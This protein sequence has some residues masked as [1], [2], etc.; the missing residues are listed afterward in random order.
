[1]SPVKPQRRN[2]LAGAVGNAIEFYD[3]IIY[4]YLAQYFAAHFFPTQDPVTGLIASYGGFAAGM[5]MRPIGGILIGAIGDRVGRAMAL[6]VSVVMIAVPTF[7]IGLLPT[8]DSVGLWAPIL[9]LLMRLIQGL[10]LGGEYPAAVVFLVEQS[11]PKGRG[12]AGSFSPLGI[13]LGLLLG[14]AVC[15]A[16]TLHLGETQMREWGWRIPFI[17]SVLLT[18]VAA[19]LRRRILLDQPPEKSS[20]R[21]LLSQAFRLYWRQMVAIALANAV[22][23]VSGF[24]GFMYV[25]PWMI[26]QAGVSSAMAYGVNFASLTLCL[27]A[28]LGGGILSD[29]IGRFRTVLLGAAIAFLGAWPAFL[30]FKTGVLPLMIVGSLLIALGQGFFTG[31]FC[32]CMAGLVPRQVRVTVMAIGFSTS[33]GVFGG[34]SPMTTEYLVG[35][36]HLAMAPAIMIM[37]AGIISLLALL[38]LPTWRNFEESFPEDRLGNKIG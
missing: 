11:E 13:V 16:V 4:A 7:L 26:R 28:T 1:M 10:S 29:R 27:L 36:L 24:V 30:C 18:I 35:K 17:A 5:L 22:A 25:V 21:S 31:P 6:Q 9:L 23:G 3:F 8:Y 2:L 12:F 19:V 32:A 20:Q 33:M 37:G 15:L 14:S 34:L 38:L